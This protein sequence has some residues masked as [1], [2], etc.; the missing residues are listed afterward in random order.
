M[1]LPRQ[2]TSTS[3]SWP[4]MGSDGS[5][6]G[7][8]AIPIGARVQL[9]P[10][11]DVNSLPLSAGGKAIARALQVYGA[12]VGDTGSMATFNGQ[13][14]VKPDGSLDSSPWAGLLTYRDLYA[15]L[16]MNRLRIVQAN[17]ADFFQEGQPVVVPT[18]TPTSTVVPPTFTN[19]PKPT[20]TFT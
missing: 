8:A 12:W 15:G 4:A 11:I 16:P 3:Y 7:G 6:S 20:N 19:T 9:D 18:N 17:S 5:A 1:N 2:V 14:F 13:E 10:S